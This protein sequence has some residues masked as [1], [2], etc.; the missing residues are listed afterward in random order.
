M[1]PEIKHG[2]TVDFPGLSLNGTLVHDPNQT[3]LWLETD[4]GPEI[5]SVN[6]ESYGMTPAP[7]NVFIKDY[8]EGAGVTDSLVAAQLVERVREGHF[9]PF[10][11]SAVECR[12]TL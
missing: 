10:D 9:G 11:A 2:V 3:G 8:S 1:V 7:G 12:V 5:L 6:L 4:E